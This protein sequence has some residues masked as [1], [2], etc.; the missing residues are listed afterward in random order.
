MTKD[1]NKQF[2]RQNEYIRNNYDRISVTV[3]P[4]T[5]QKIIDLGYSVNAYINE[6]IKNDLE[7]RL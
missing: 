7:K 5:K 2:K 6:L 3:P 4:G 1:K